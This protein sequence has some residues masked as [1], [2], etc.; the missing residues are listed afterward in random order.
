MKR[1]IAAAFSLFVPVL[2]AE[3]IWVVDSNTTEELVEIVWSENDEGDELSFFRCEDVLENGFGGCTE[4][5]S[6]WFT[7]MKGKEYERYVFKETPA[8]FVDGKYHTILNQA[9]GGMLTVPIDDV[10]EYVVVLSRNEDVVSSISFSVSLAAVDYFYAHGTSALEGIYLEFNLGVTV[11]NVWFWLLAF[12]DVGLPHE[13]YYTASTDPEVYAKVA[14]PFPFG[15]C[16]SY[17]A[18][19]KSWMKRTPGYGLPCWKN[20]KRDYMSAA[21]LSPIRRGFLKFYF[22]YG[23]RYYI[24]PFPYGDR[25]PPSGNPMIMDYVDICSSATSR[26]EKHVVQ[27]GEP[28][29]IAVNLQIDGGSTNCSVKTIE[30]LSNL[31]SK[32][33]DELVK[34]ETNWT[35]RALASTNQ[36]TRMLV[37]FGGT[38][39]RNDYTE[40]EVSIAP[41]LVGTYLLSVYSKLSGF[42]LDEYAL[43]VTPGNFSAL[44]SFV[45]DP[46]FSAKTVKIN[47]L[48]STV[49]TAFDK[50]ENRIY[51]GGEK[52]LIET[53]P[54]VP[55][56]TLLQV[57]DQN[58]GT[59]RL[60]FNWSIRGL[61]AVQVFVYTP[62]TNEKM[63]I[64]GSPATF[65][66][67]DQSV[68]YVDDYIV[69]VSDCEPRGLAAVKTVALQWSPTRTCVDGTLPQE[70]SYFCA[71][72]QSLAGTGVIVGI[73]SG[74]GITVAVLWAGVVLKYETSATL[75]IVGRVNILLMCIGAILISSAPLLFLSSN[76]TIGPISINF[77][78][79]L[80]LGVLF[81]LAFKLA[82][83]QI[84]CVTYMRLN[85][86]ATMPTETIMEKTLAEKS[87]APLL[88]L[89][90][91][92]LIGT[93]NSSPNALT[94]QN[95]TI[96]EDPIAGSII[97]ETCGDTSGSSIP[98]ILFALKVGLLSITL[99]LVLSLTKI[100]VTGKMHLGRW[101]TRSVFVLILV[102]GMTSMVTETGM[103]KNPAGRAI[104]R[105]VGASM[106]SSVSLS[107]VLWR[108]FTLRH[109]QFESMRMFSSMASRKQSGSVTRSSFLGTS[110][111]APSTTAGSLPSLPPSSTLPSQAE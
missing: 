99:A 111:V 14:R 83:L 91:V 82:K 58:D 24:I 8:R 44:D 30:N 7:N 68:C 60:N 23:K 52:I 35:S 85:D 109:L 46:S 80:F 102:G 17:A 20:A 1:L 63:N 10:D 43:T 70:H 4:S 39:S 12:E 76:C 74:I 21:G 84:R 100:H 101:L 96:A 62:A 110:S 36:S 71:N 48:Y 90:D 72:T 64:K 87:L 65:N 22:P 106:A 89:L 59:Y 13:Q 77:G 28:A 98:D 49:L 6:V 103:V 47:E 29:K 73:L 41:P 51:S 45:D 105:A 75:R 15:G 108:A 56:E 11:P 27:A 92:L 86:G 57:V 95:I 50:F 104:L 25:T 54:K 3:V 32:H 2:D 42:K 67:F 18:T 38:T 9:G 40:N 31:K 88:L 69:S 97:D 16:W 81:A 78:A 66:V 107:C 33:T 26:P 19:V 79:D 5:V 61:F 53:F 94:F 37:K 34:V 55:N 93:W